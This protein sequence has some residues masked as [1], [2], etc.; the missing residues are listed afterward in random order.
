[1]M[2]RAF[3][4]AAQSRFYLAV[5]LCTLSSIVP[6]QA[7]AAPDPGQASVSGSEQASTV[8]PQPAAQ[9]VEA[10][11]GGTEFPVIRTLGG[12]ALVIS[13]ILIAFLVA[14]KVAPQYFNRRTTER[15]LR[16][17]ESLSVGEKRSIGLIQVG[18]KRFLIGNTPNQITLLSQLE[19]SVSLIAEG[20]KTTS[21]ELSNPSP[22]NPFRRLYETERYREASKVGKEKSIPPDVRA[23]MRQLREALEG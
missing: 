7:I 18:D 23:K 5:L 22:V 4:S 9:A 17:I 8:S 20:E 6:K 19:D 1:M 12:F 3:L 16:V 13:L 14:R 11:T 21:T 15:N 2:T 10:P